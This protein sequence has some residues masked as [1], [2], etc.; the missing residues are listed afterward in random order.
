MIRD[1]HFDRTL[2][3]LDWEAVRTEFRPQAVAATTPEELRAVIEAMLARL[4]Q[5]HFQVI[6]NADGGGASPRTAAVAAGAASES[7]EPPVAAHTERLDGT[8]GVDVRLIDDRVVVRAVEPDSSAAAAG[9]RPG[10]TVERVDQLDAETALA[11]VPAG[12]E[13]A[14][15][16]FVATQTVATLLDGAEGETKS[17]RFRNQNDQP[18]DLELTL[19]PIPGDVVRFGG[20]PALHARLTS[21]WIAAEE[22]ATAELAT[23]EASGAA[24]RPAGD[25]LSI[26]LIAFNIWMVP[27]AA[28]FHQAIDT[29]READ[30]LIIDLRGNPGGIGALAMGLAGHFCDTP[31]SLGTMRTR[32]GD[33]E[34]RANP[35]RTD[36]AGER[37]EPYAGP[38][39]LLIDEMTG[40][41]SEVF[42]GGLQC[43]GRVRVFGTRSA[44]AAL[45]A[46]MSTLPNGDTLLHAIADFTTPDGTRL[47]GRGVVPDENVPLTRADLLADRDAPLLAALRWIDRVTIAPPERSN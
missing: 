35:R 3:G 9:V 34:F 12:L 32:G 11:D 8:V 33:L 31:L 19:L 28:P 37:V 39:A 26:G 17:I 42:A 10:W 23:T 5:S 16:T 13:G 41:T 44:G 47:E 43:H 36:V 30:G 2:S 24:A 14:W 25:E 20:L 6:P 22:L 15:M 1:T 7:S 38:V 27:V 21:R 4:G 18:V 29:F 45:P 46:Q 40:S